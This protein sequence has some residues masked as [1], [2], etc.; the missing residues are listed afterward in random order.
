MLDRAKEHGFE[1]WL[2]LGHP[3]KLAKLV[4]GEWDTHSA[5]SSSAVPVVTQLAS[6]LLKLLPPESATVEGIFEALA[7]PAR[8][9]LA[10][11]LATKIRSA[12]SERIGSQQ[13]MSVALINLA[14]DL[15]GSCGDLTPWR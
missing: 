13:A 15:I 8:A 1:R 2:V 9:Q 7:E 14:G 12:I 4:L 5:H 10:D 3:G 6:S 11:L